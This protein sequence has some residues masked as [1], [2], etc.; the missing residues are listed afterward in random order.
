MLADVLGAHLAVA[1]VPEDVVFL[2][3]LGPVAGV[4]GGVAGVLGVGDAEVAEDVLGSKGEACSF[5]L[6]TEFDVVGLER[7]L[8]RRPLAR[9]NLTDDVIDLQAQVY[10][11]FDWII[12]FEVV[13]DA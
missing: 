11:V 2:V 8:L 6:V 9:V 7:G 1:V 3:L 13:E 4:L 12:L 10:L 5:V